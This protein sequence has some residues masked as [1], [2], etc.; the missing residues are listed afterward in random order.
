MKLVDYESSDSDT[1]VEESTNTPSK[2]AQ[3]DD[4]PVIMLDIKGGYRH[5]T[6]IGSGTDDSES[7]S[8]SSSLSSSDTSD[9]SSSEEDI[10]EQMVSRER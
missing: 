9:L 2:P 10:V 5:I 8:E 4:T 6:D 3:E 7:D 1:D